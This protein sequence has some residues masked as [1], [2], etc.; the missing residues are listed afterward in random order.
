[1]KEKWITIPFESNYE[2]S[3]KGRIRNI[4]TKHIKKLRNDRYGYLRVTLYPS[5][6]TY[7]V[8]RLVMLSFMPEHKD[9]Q[10]NHIN[11]DKEDNNIENLEWCSASHNQR[12]YRTKLSSQ[13]KGQLNPSSQLTYNQALEIKYGNF[14]LMSNREIGEVFGVYDECVRLIRNGTNW[15]HI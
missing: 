7:T 1:M 2:V 5:G 8:H 12:H 15:S 6:K 14:G 9:E 11:G 3:T 13:W 4:E 10:I